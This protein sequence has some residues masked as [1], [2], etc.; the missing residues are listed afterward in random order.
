M[1]KRAEYIAKMKSQLD[2]L[3]SEIASLE[4]KASDAKE[5]A[6]DK[7]HEQIQKLREQ[8]HLVAAKL[9]EIKA[10]GEESWE[11]LVTETEKVRDAF[12]HSFNYFKSQL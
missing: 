11:N 5:S 4:A 1:S 8:S 7:Y 6:R 10:A 2:D 12:V 3:N 9:E